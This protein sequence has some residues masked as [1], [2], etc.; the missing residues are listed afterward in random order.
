MIVGIPA[1][2]QS[3]RDAQEPR[4][5]GRMFSAPSPRPHVDVSPTGPE[6]FVSK[7]IPGGGELIDK[8]TRW[9]LLGIWRP[10]KT[11]KR[12]PLVLSDSR[13][14]PATDYRDLPRDKS[15]PADWKWVVSLLKPGNGHRWHY[16]SDMA[17]DEVFIF[18]HY[19]SNHDLPAW[20]CVHTSVPIPGTENLPPRESVEARILVG[21]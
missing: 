3:A 15:K 14:V 21:Y 20:R 6:H 1:I 18:K 10:L 16:L 7:L 13:S 2:R 8:A 12:D 4:P 17:P 9:Q 5:V 11:I 19:D